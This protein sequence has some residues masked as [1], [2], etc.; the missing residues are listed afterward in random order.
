M[1]NHLLVRRA[2]IAGLLV[3]VTSVGCTKTVTHQLARYEPGLAATTRPAPDTAVYKVKIRDR[4][5][6]KFRGIDGT[7]SLV[8]EGQPLGFATDEHGVVYAIAGHQTFP[9]TMTTID[10]PIIW[11][12]EYERQT[13]FGKEV[14]KVAE[15]SGKVAVGAA[16]VGVVGAALWADSL[17]DDDCDRSHHRHHKHHH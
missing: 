16:V 11:H 13:Q 8:L 7:E 17:D 9:L 4:D 1:C 5:G 12:T 6:R 15:A 10:R 14:G 2:L 3:S